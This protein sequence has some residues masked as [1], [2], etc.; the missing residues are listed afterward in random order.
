MTIKEVEKVVI[1]QGNL[2]SLFEFYDK[3]DEV[4][5]RTL[6]EATMIYLNKFNKT[7]IEIMSKIPKIIYD[8]LECRRDSA[9]IEEERL[10]EYVLVQLWPVIAEKEVDRILKEAKSEFRSKTR[11]YKLMI[12]KSKEV[13]KDT[14]KILR[15]VLLKNQYEV[16]LEKSHGDTAKSSISEAQDSQSQGVQSKL[17]IPS[18]LKVQAAD[19]KVE[20]VEVNASSAPKAPGDHQVEIDVPSYPV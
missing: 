11:I 19:S 4:G 3:F 9:K 13:M 15:S 6:E 12:V 10:R 5:Q 2:K 16:V 14:E 18:V 1:V 8:V 7:L 17:D 20:Q